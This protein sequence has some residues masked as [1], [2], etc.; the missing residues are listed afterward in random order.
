[1]TFDTTSKGYWLVHSETEGGRHYFGPFATEYDAEDYVDNYL[2]NIEHKV[3]F[4]PQ[5]V[6]TED[7]LP[8][9]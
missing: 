2:I 4:Y 3:V 7:E 5:D 1:M 6:V 9:A 8:P